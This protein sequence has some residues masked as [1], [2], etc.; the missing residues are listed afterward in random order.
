MA[1]LLGLMLLRRRLSRAGLTVLLVG[2][3]L[4]LHAAGCGCSDNLQCRIDDD[5]SKM[6]CAAGKIPQCQT[7]MCI[8]ASDLAPGDIG[9]FS[10]MT[11]V[12]STAY[13]AAYNNTY[14]DLMIGHVTPPG[15]VTDWDYVDGVPG[16]PPDIQGS[17]V[18]GG[19]MGMGDD[20]GRY[21]SIQTTPG[22]DPVIAYYDKTHGSLKYASFGAIRWHTYT[23]DK[24]DGAPEGGGD[25]IG[26]WTSL[27]LDGN[28]VPGIAYS[29]LLLSQGQGQIRWAQ[30][31]G[32]DPQAPSDWTIT[33]IDSRPLGQQVSAP[34]GGVPPDLG[35]T[36]DP[37]LPESIAIMA[38]AARKADGTPA[39]AYYDRGRGNLRYA[40]LTGGKWTATILDGEAGTGADTG[41]V[42]QYPSLAFDDTGVAHISY[43]DATHDNLLYVN[44]K[45][46]TPEVADDGYRPMDEQTLDPTPIASPVYHLVGDSSSIQVVSG[47]VVIA[48]QDSTTEQLRYATRGQDGKWVTKDVAGHSNP[49]RGAYGFYAN[50]RILNHQGIIS[51]YAINQQLDNPSYYV[52]V[53]A[54]DLG[55]IM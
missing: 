29:A 9:R 7:N 38:S 17:H 36:G 4:A 21:T 2:G 13:V 20:V 39:L 50:L 35:M 3:G 19:V 14:G 33:V 44:S 25:D 16:D 8:C 53:F 40:E 5:C 1:S 47:L 49:F 15:V 46:K 6:Q 12:G 24:G 54:V 43:V 41:D 23:I 26:R 34:D 31:N 28:G 48:Y 22:N 52:E 30:A 55:L 10:S 45:T 42:G 37:L 27:S 18:R 32:P 51:S 11:M